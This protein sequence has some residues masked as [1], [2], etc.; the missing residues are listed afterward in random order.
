MEEHFGTYTTVIVNFWPARV[1]TKICN[2]KDSTQNKRRRGFRFSAI[3]RGTILKLRQFSKFKR[4]L[5]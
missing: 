4:I 3:K 5:V 1:Q 2:L